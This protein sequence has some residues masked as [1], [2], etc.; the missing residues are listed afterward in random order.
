MVAE[1]ILSKLSS[2]GL[3]P[4]AAAQIFN[5]YKEESLNLIEEYPYLLVEESPRNR[6]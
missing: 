1:Q 4:K 6:I 3:T 5:Q 2:Y